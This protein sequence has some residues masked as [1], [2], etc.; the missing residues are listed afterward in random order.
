MSSD[1]HYSVPCATHKRASFGIPPFGWLAAR[2][3]EV[4]IAAEVLHDIQ[5]AAPWDHS[6]PPP[7][8][9]EQSETAARR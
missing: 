8:R 3:R 2:F 5:W 4:M 6:Q 1:V 7:S 9:S